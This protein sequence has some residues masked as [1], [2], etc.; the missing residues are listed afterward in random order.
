MNK[1]IL[2]N[3]DNPIKQKYLEKLD[4]IEVKDVLNENIFVDK[5]TYN[6][7]LE[8]KEYLR[9]FLNPIYIPKKFLVWPQNIDFNF[10]IK[11]SVLIEYVDKG[12]K[13]NSVFFELNS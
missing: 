2:I 11:R 13:V 6:K 9:R 10:K 7:Y 1:T 4:L 5:E 12:I 8:L 3:K